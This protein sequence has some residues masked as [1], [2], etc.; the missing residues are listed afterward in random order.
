MPT[1]RR[2]NRYR[3]VEPHCNLMCL[4]MVPILVGGMAE[5]DADT[6]ADPGMA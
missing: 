6:G 1:Q 2:F 3:G 5:K 4:M